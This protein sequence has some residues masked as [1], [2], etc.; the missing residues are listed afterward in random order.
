ML[1]LLSFHQSGAPFPKELVCDESRALLNVAVGVYART[2][3][4][5][6]DYADHLESADITTRIRQDVAHL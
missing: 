4:D 6:N 2:Y 3:T 5:I 1:F